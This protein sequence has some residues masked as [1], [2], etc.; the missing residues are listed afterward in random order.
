MSQANRA[1]GSFFL[2][3]NRGFF[4]FSRQGDCPFSK[5]NSTR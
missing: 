1:D 2:A 4:G 3:L 5:A